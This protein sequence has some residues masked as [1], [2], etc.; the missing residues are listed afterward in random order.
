MPSANTDSFSNAPPLNRL[1]RAKTLPPWADAIPMHAWTAD[2]EMPGV[3]SA[4]PSRKTAI[5]QMV[6]SS[7]RRRSGVRNARRNAVSMC[8]PRLDRSTQG[9]GTRAA[10]AAA[11]GC[12]LRLPQCNVLAAL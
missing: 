10:L 7:F 2:S 6:K 8:R 5:M 11:C 9:S 1:T 12:R 4:A 3:G